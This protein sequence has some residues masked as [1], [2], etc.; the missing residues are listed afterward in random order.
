MKQKERLDPLHL[1]F[2]KY[3]FGSPLLM[4]MNNE[5]GKMESYGGVGA[6]EMRITQKL[7]LVVFTDKA[8][9]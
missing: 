1:P 2:P 9:E 5:K 8:K 6:Q 3:F 7:L 4:K